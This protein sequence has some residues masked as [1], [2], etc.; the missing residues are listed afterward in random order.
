MRRLIFDALFVIAKS[1]LLKFDPIGAVLAHCRGEIDPG[2]GADSSDRDNED[3]CRSKS[4]FGEARQS[5]LFRTPGTSAVV[6][7]KRRSASSPGV[8][9]SGN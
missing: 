5:G 6:E 7:G 4:H 3:D 9:L 8:H 2:S 1:E